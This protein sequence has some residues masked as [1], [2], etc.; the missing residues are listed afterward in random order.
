MSSSFCVWRPQTV[1]KNESIKDG[2][3]VVDVPTEVEQQRF[4]ELATVY[5]V[6]LAKVVA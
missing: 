1:S 6:V 3:Y 5:A 4:G 2:P